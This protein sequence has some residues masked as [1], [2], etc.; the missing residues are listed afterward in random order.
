M[1]VIIQIGYM[2]SMNRRRYG[3]SVRAYINDNECSWKDG[4]GEFISSKVDA[5]KGVLWY[6]WM[7]DLSSDDGIKLEV[8][9]F[10]VGAGP[11]E[12]RT[13]ETIYYV[14]EKAPIREVIMHGVGCKGYP[15]I[16]GRIL[17]IGSV[18]EKD[19]RESKV[20]EFLDNEG[21]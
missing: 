13:F 20:Y 18:S 19:K 17:E 21:F 15:I 1:K 16:K 8:K 12:T 4:N 11:D 2:K 10:I 3:Q 7:G 14:D 5:S 6:L 9:T